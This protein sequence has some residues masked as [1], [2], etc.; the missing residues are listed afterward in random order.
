MIAD[1]AVF[2][3]LS[4]FCLLSEHLI[5]TFSITPGMW[6]GK[7]QKSKSEHSVG[8]ADFLCRMR[9]G[10]Y[11]QSGGNISLGYIPRC[12]KKSG[13]S[14]PDFSLSNGSRLRMIVVK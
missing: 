4:L 13:L 12:N 10:I 14:K 11:R 1:S 9:K 7:A 8:E 6:R 3:C 5:F 2:P